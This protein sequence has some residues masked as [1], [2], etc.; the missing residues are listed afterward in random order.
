M[1]SEGEHRDD[2][3]FRRGAWAV[4]LLTCGYIVG[5]MSTLEEGPTGWIIGIIAAPFAGAAVTFMALVGFIA[6]G[7]VIMGA[8]QFGHA[9]G[10]WLS[11]TVA[12]PASGRRAAAEG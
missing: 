8:W 3:R 6:F 11:A 5:M 12:R 7:Y 9:I 4:F 1:S 10:V 2:R